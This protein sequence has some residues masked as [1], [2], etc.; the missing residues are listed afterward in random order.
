MYMPRCFCTYKKHHLL[1][2]Q[3]RLSQN[4][5]LESDGKIF[6]DILTDIYLNTIGKLASQVGFGI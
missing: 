2:H 4:V 3:E 5:K 6:D 1:S